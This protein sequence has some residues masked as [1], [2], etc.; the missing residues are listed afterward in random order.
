MLEALVK[1]LGT[2]RRGRTVE[3]LQTKLGWTRGQV[4]NAIRRA[5][6]KGLIEAVAGD[7]YR[8]KM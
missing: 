5:A 2:A 4:R 1:A 7:V 6:T 3:Q 8:R